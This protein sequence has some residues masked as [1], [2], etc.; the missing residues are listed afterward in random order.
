[1]VIDYSVVSFGGR[2]I[3]RGCC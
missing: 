3:K 1:M 2:W